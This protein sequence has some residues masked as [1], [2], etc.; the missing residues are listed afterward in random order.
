MAVIA[1]PATLGDRLKEGAI[2]AL[3]DAALSTGEGR[4]AAHR[5]DELQLHAGGR[6]IGLC[7]RTDLPFAPRAAG[8]PPGVS[9]KRRL[10][11]VLPT[12]AAA[13]IAS[14]T[15]PSGW[16]IELTGDTDDRLDPRLRLAAVRLRIE[17][18]RRYQSA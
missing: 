8:D 2:N 17:I 1:D 18:E 13:A 6:L 7:R 5:A 3:V 15:R 11:S 16:R 9:P 10:A 4:A 14:A 12:R